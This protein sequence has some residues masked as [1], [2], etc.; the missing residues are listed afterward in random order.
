MKRRIFCWLM[1]VALLLPGLTLTV[2]ADCGPKPSTYVKILGGGGER[3]I[4]TLFSEKIQFGPY[5]SIQADQEAPDHLTENQAAAWAAF[6]AY[7]DPDG[8]C[9]VG[10]VW[11]F[12]VDWYYYPPESFKIAVYYPDYDVL[13]VSDQV[14]QRYAFHSDFFVTLPRLSEDAQSGVVDMVV[15]RD[16]DWMEDAWNLFLRILVT[17]LAEL[18]LALAWKYNAS[19]QLRCI[20][21]VNLLTQVGLNL[22]LW[23]WYYFD[24]PLD[25]LLRLAVAEVVVLL[26]E[27]L[28]YLR[29][30]PNRGSSL[31]TVG[32]TLTAN[33]ASVWLGFLLLD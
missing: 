9:F 15:R 8:F 33:L 30:L 21:R 25:A 4:L 7:D 23:L 18:L 24:G 26:V 13:L 22:L 16:T 1:C 19:G 5:S 28:L 32:Y 29:K 27:V 10:E 3:M 11:D 6:A 14:F 31:K 17:L 12:D 2:R 20:L